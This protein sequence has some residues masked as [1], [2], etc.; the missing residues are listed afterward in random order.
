MDNTFGSLFSG[1]GGLDLGLERAGLKCTFQVENDRHCLTLLERHWPDVPK[2]EIRPCAGIVGGDPCPVRSSLGNASKTTKPD[3]SGHFLAMVARCEPR[4]VLRENVRAPDVIDFVTGL[5]VL[6]YHCCIIE[7]SSAAFT[8]QSRGREFVVGF[9]TKKAAK[10]FETVVTEQ[11][12]QDNYQVCVPKQEAARCLNSRGR[13]GVSIYQD[14][15]YEEGD[16]ALYEER[17]LAGFTSL[18]RAK[19]LMAEVVGNFVKDSK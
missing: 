5:E 19:Q 17:D 8:G 2:N 1:G 7:A 3:M 18:K 11:S 15:V 9:D 4:W 16:P 12:N 6:S 10:R 13:S 14:F